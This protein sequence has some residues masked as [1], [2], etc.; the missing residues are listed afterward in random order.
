MITEQSDTIGQL[1]ALMQR[2][3]RVHLV[4]IGGVSVS[5]LAEVL[6]KN[7]LSVTGS[8][9]RA[10]EV[11]ERLQAL[12]IPVFIGHSADNLGSAEFVVRTAA[13]RDDNAEIAAARA[14]GIPVFERAEAWG[15]IMRGYKNAV[16]I[17]GAHGKTT[18][19]SM[20]AHIL[21]AA[22]LDPTVMIGGT[23][24]SLGSGYRVG[25]GDTIVLESCEYYDSFLSFAPTVAVVLNIDADHLDYFGTL[26]N[27]KASFREFALKTPENGLVIVCGDD[28]NTTDALAGIDREVLTFGF[29]NGCDVRCESASLEGKGSL[30]NVVYEDRVYCK[31][32][33]R[34]P[35]R[36]N[37]SN[38]L[39][40]CAA[41]I[42]LGVPAEVIEDSLAG[43]TGAE[44]RF[45][46]RG[47]CGGADVY[48]DYAHHPTELRALFDAARELPYNRVIAA[49]QPHTYS[50]TSQHFD[51]FVRELSR[52]DKLFLVDIYAARETNTYGIESTD[53]VRAI[54]GSVYCES[55]DALAA[56]LRAE[57]RPGD[58]I[59][60][61][62]AGELNKVAAQLTAES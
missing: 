61:I 34:V 59:L 3:A 13:A 1:T 54:P 8:D 28:A 43:F 2:G 26:E 37:I 6:L 53:L 44:R 48:D 19:T 42:Y 62:G 33:L 12:G 46:Y 49:F 47:E 14:A 25:S 38:A 56:A 5:P 27:V 31:L 10:S 18:T 35:G 22:E 23:L 60:T 11:T 24:S 32:H 52:A 36:H 17:A 58:L 41:A 4:G 15:V 50:R 30:F 57:A 29:G 55:F 7:G 16:C 39:A 9:L 20:T 51:A 45:D 40:A 21:L